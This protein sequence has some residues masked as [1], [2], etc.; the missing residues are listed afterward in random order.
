MSTKIQIDNAAGNLVVDGQSISSAITA[1]AQS[2]GQTLMSGSDLSWSYQ[3]AFLSWRNKLINGSMAIAQRGGS[4]VSSVNS[5]QAYAPDRWCLLNATATAVSVQRDTVVPTASG[6]TN[7]LTVSTTT[8]TNSTGAQNIILIQRIEGANLQELQYGTSSAKPLT[9]SFWVRSSVAG[10]YSGAVAMYPVSGSNVASYVWTYTIDAANTWEKKVIT[11]PGNQTYAM[12]TSSTGYMGFVF[13]LGSGPSAET[14]AGS[15]QL[16]DFCRT[17]S[18][19]KWANNSSVYF[20]VTG[21]QLEVGTVATPFEHLPYSES[22]N[23]CKR[24][25]ARMSAA[26]TSSVFASGC[27]GTTTLAW[28]YLKYEQQMRSAPTITLS[29]LTASSGSNKTYASTGSVYAGTDSALFGVNTSTAAVVGNGGV[30][31]ATSATGYIELNAEL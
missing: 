13:D 30:L 14:T 26:S 20:Y 22:L 27:W 23:L 15:W 24:Y 11:I 3:D 17:S 4:A 10:T 12:P 8:A 29:G 25:Y 19:V 5:S 1:N 31:I 2:A 28:F 7:S 6:F 18:S 21:V 16:G 9:A